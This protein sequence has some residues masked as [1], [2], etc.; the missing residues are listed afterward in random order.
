MTESLRLAAIAGDLIRNDRIDW[1]GL[2]DY[3]NSM[4][5]VLDELE[6]VYV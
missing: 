1:K 2:T 5:D 4:Y 3:S 6:V